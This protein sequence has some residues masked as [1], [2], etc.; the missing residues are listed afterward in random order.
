MIAGS[1]VA[2]TIAPTLTTS[3]NTIVPS[4]TNSYNLGS[5]LRFWL[6]TYSSNYWLG[7]T[8]KIILNGNH[9]DHNVPSGAFH[10]FQT[11]STIPLVVDELSIRPVIDGSIIS[12]SC[13][14]SSEKWDKIWAVNS[15]IQTSD[16][17]H[18]NTIVTLP[19]SLGLSFIESLNPVTYKFNNVDYV[20]EDGTTGTTVHTRTHLGLIAQEVKAEIEN[21]GLTLNDVDIVD[22][23]YLVDPVNGNDLYAVRYSNLIAPLI[24][25]IQELST[26]MTTMNSTLVSLDTRISALANP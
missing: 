9:I 1:T 17:R 14:S 18:K 3:Y 2:L 5:S 20:N 21:I 13:G 19:S 4:T 25:A 23:D 7:S 22:N 24:K 10:R 16:I 26:S 6:N 12:Y 11:G 15:L 8:Q